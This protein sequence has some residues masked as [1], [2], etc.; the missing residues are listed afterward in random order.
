MKTTLLF[1]IGLITLTLIVGLIIKNQTTRN[2]LKSKSDRK[3]LMENGKPVLKQ[4]GDLKP[5]DFEDYPIWVQCHI[6][7]YGENW[8][9]DTD[10]ETFRPWIDQTPV[11]PDYA[12]FLIKSELKLN[13]GEIYMGFITP[14]LETDH[15]NE[16][17]LGFIQ[18]QIF[19]KNGERI[20]FWTGTFPIDQ[21]EIAN[22]F[23]K[24]DKTADQI[25]P[26][27][28]K[29]IEGLARG[30]ASGNINGFLTM[31]EKNNIVI[32]K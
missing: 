11:S 4:Y 18:P 15:K 6:I 5:Q 31:P 32:T 3:V 29:S 27:L 8:Y 30:V 25:F 20:G 26:I 13:D 1:I 17:D 21:S 16:N 24:M 9:D 28:F 19:T 22:F 10:E 2:K 7:D 12:M 23:K 14:C